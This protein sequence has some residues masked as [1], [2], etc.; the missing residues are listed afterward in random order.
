LE[1]RATVDRFNF[2]L[3]LGPT[4]TIADAES[5]RA[6]QASWVHQGLP[7]LPDSGVPAGSYAPGGSDKSD[8]DFLLGAY[9]AVGVTLDI[10][11]S[12]SLGVE[13]RYDYVNG[14]AGTSQAELDLS[15]SSGILRLGYRF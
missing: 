3:A 4:L 14:D 15:G 8:I 6:M 2:T 10:S 13:Y 5:S 11:T 12:W 7:G 1:G 9:A